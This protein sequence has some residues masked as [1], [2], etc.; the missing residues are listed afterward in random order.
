MLTNEMQMRAELLGKVLATGIEPL[1][2]LDH[3]RKL[4]DFIDYGNNMISVTVTDDAADIFAECDI[5]GIRHGADGQWHRIAANRVVYDAEPA[6]F[7]SHP[8]YSRIG[9]ICVDDQHL[10]E[11]PAFY[12]RTERNG[13]EQTWL[14]SSRPAGGFILHP[15]FR[16]PD[17]SVA[18]AIRIGAYA[19]GQRDG[20]VAVG[21][22][23]KPWTSVSFDAAQERCEAIGPGWRMWSI[24]DLSAIQILAMIEMGGTD[25]QD[26]IGRGQVD[27][28]G[29]VAGGDSRARWRGIHELWGNVWQMVDGLRIAADGTINVWSIDRPGSGEWVST[30]VQY[31]PG[32]DHGYPVSLHS[33]R[34]NGFDLS[35]LFL[36]SE[37]TSD[38]DDALIGDWVWGH[39]EG[40]ET[41]AYCGGHWNSGVNA[42]VFALNLRDA[43]SSTGAALGFRPAFAI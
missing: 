40:R 27:G 32:G 11:I 36:P 3:A 26:L 39:W 19:A 9:P 7:A 28:G 13:D 23:L 24:Y 37:V 20:D 4:W 30:G 31:G 1:T 18:K 43:R 16:N 33:E 12:V 22:G 42:G 35:L 2:A 41:V 10:V 14:V 21:A 25:M 6:V 15:A 38:Q 5:I 29:V 34:G 17:G 8:I